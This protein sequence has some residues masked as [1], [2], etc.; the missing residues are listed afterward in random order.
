MVDDPTIW[1]EWPKKIRPAPKPLKPEDVHRLFRLIQEPPQLAAWRRPI[2]QRNVL[3]IELM[4]FAGLRLS[5][6]ANL[7]WEHIDLV[8]ALLMVFD[9]KGGKDR[10][11]PLHHRLQQRLSA[12]PMAERVGTV[13]KTQTGKPC[14]DDCLEHIFSRWLRGLGMTCHAHRLRHTFATQM[15]R[16]GADLRS[17]QVVMGHESLETTMQY[18]LVDPEQTRAAVDCMPADW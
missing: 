10:V 5:E 1:V 15:L 6:A 14:S 13:L 3:A 17:I 12:I 2:W 9:G 18:I 16:H 4:L 11:I 7:R 8:D